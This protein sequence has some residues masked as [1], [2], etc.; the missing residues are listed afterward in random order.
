MGKITSWWSTG[1]DLPSTAQYA[2][3][4]PS[5][6]FMLLIHVQLDIYQDLQVLFYQGAFQLHGLQ[7]VLVPYQVQSSAILLVE[8]HEILVSPFLK[9]VKVPLSGFRVLQ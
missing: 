6:K 1:S 7:H 5:D 4:L 3:G 8:L 2:I 9:S